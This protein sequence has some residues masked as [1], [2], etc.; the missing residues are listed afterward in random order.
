MHH[1][2]TTIIYTTFERDCGRGQDRKPEPKAMKVT[3][4]LKTDKGEEGYRNL[5]MVIF[6][7][8]NYVGVW[9]RETWDVIPEDELDVDDD[10][11]TFIRKDSPGYRKGKSDW[12]QRSYH[13]SGWRNDGVG[14]VL[15]ENRDRIS[16][17]QAINHWFELV[18]PEKLG[19]PKPK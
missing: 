11:D 1:L 19:L 15:S 2:L 8:G 5:E 12:V 13:D 6:A 4:G 10:G 17:I 9:T 14:R 18:D 7:P 3:L 16:T